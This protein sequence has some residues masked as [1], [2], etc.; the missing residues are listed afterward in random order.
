MHSVYIDAKPD[1]IAE[2]QF[3]VGDH[4]PFAVLYHIAQ[5][6]E[7]RTVNK[8]IARVILDHPLL[9]GP[10]AKVRSI[11]IPCNASS[12]WPSRQ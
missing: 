11:C 5:T 2:F 1:C 7:Q 3:S 9:G 8:Q 4:D 12:H 6:I 10:E